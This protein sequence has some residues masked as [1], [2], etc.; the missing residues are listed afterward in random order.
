MG[1]GDRRFWCRV[2][3]Q[4]VFGGHCRR[5]AL[6]GRHR[7]PNRRRARAPGPRRP[8]R[9]QLRGQD[10]AAQR[11]LVR[12]PPARDSALERGWAD[13]PGRSLLR[14]GC[15]PAPRR[16]GLHLLRS[17]AFFRRMAR[18]R[19]R[20]SI[21]ILLAFQVRRGSGAFEATERRRR[22]ASNADR[23]DARAA[24]LGD[25]ACRL[26]RSHRRRDHVRAPARH[27]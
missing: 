7:R 6:D 13:H 19:L 24:Q 9:H 4:A 27:R 3:G 21:I 17:I 1:H 20:E 10:R 18:G 14:A 15:V 12:Y 8:G 23:R 11:G 22:Q 2:S 16:I 26:P 25:Q 5:G